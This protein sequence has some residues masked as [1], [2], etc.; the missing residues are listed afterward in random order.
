MT[1]LD[2]AILSPLFSDQKIADLLSDEAFVR[3]LVDV[4]I[5]LARA[6]ARLGVIPRN[7]AERIAEVRPQT[8]DVQTL[9][10]GTLRSGFPI[11]ALV[12]ELRKQVG[13]E[14][15]P[16]VHWGATTQDIVDTASILQIR[17]AIELF[18]SRIIDIVRY[19][20][21]LADRHRNLVLAARTH[22]QRAA[23]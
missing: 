18:K 17:S 15:A 20:S 5:A 21:A 16:F 19:L 2:A 23:P 8:I 3:A 4:E 12:E 9:T 11:I 7:A 13:S 1:T 14:A 10:K 6:E 22:G